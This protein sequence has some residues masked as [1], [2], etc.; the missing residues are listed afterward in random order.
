MRWPRYAL[1]L[2]FVAAT[3]NIIRLARTLGWL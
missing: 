1:P 2:M 3:L